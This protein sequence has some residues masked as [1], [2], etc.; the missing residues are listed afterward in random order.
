MIK[1]DVEGYEEAVVRG[2]KKL[3]ASDSLKLSE[4]E[5][6]TPQIA[7]IFDDHGFKQAYYDPFRR[8]LTTSPNELPASN[9]VFIRDW[10]FVA[11]RLMTAPAIHVLGK[12]I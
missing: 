8:A 7:D 11:T 5:T 2:A 9:S 4:L 6:L 3:I 10:E 1:M 12:S